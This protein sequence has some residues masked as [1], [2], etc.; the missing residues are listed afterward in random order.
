M[1]TPLNYPIFGKF[2]VTKYNFFV[3]VV[4]AIFAYNIFVFHVI[5]LKQAPSGSNHG[6]EVLRKS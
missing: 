6:I 4:L 5:V 1:K 2:K 3:M